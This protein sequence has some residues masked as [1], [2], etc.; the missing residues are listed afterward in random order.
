MGAT[1][2][3]EVLQNLSYENRLRQLGLFSL[4]KGKLR[5]DLINI[6][7]VYDGRVSREWIQALLGVAKQ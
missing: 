7:S 4:K 1:K 6:L 2:I 5:G 3:I